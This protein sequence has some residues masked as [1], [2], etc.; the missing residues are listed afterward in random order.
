VALRVVA[1]H[2]DVLEVR[3]FAGQPG[4]PGIERL[5]HHQHPGAAV[6]QHEAVVVLGHQRVDRHRDD[7]GLQAA[8]KRRRPIDGVEQAD[9]N[10]LLAL[11]AER[12]QRAG[13]SRHAVG[14]LAVGP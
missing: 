6:G 12:A 13:K 2:D 1:R 3:K 7:A 11:H 4:E 10:A 9:E 8:E 5:R 14:E